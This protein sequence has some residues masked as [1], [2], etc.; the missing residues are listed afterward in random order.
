MA[1]NKIKVD[2]EEETRD[3]FGGVP[4]APDTGLIDEDRPAWLGY[5]PGIKEEDVT[6]AHECDVLVLGAGIAGISAARAAAE[7]G[8]N[9][10]VVEQS[11]SI[12]I[13]GK[14]FGCV[15]SH[16]HKELG[17]ET[18]KMDLLNL[19]MRRMGWRPNARLWKMWLDESGEAFD[20]FEAPAVKSGLEFGQHLQYWPN[21]P[22]Y[23]R[24]REL[25]PQYCAGIEFD[26][27]YGACKLHY[28]ESVAHGAKYF[29]RTTA[30]ELIKSEKGIMGAYATAEDGSLLKFTARK[31]VILATGDYGHNKEMAKALC[32]EFYNTLGLVA[33][34]W[35]T[36]MGHKMAI[37]A[38]GMMEEGPHA[39][40]SHSFPGSFVMGTTATLDLNAN[41]DRFMNE[42]V[43]GQIFTNQIIRQPFKYAWQIYD[44]NWADML[45][46]QN[47]AHGAIDINL[48]SPEKLEKSFE[49]AR[50]GKGWNMVAAD[51]L[52]ELIE[53]TGMPKERALE[54]I[55]RYNELCEKGVDEDFGKRGDRMYALVKPPFYACKSFI[56]RGMI[57]GGVVVD[58]ECRVLEKDTWKPLG[59]LYAIGNTGGGRYYC[60]YPVSPVCATS[61]GT[62][63]TFGRHVGMAAAKLADR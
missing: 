19:I 49:A 22:K 26:D 40:I 61:H 28:N 32:P 13:R 45:D 60:D 25:F 11:K 53:K 41:G 55:R 4:D 20:W 47:I 56:A 44:S 43:P 23:D 9:V 16:I 59:G 46:N 38:G 24:S 21:P 18:D 1:E 17:C 62:A 37:W 14:V 27:W 15:D 5:A 6:A 8:A 50:E 39:H 48:N 7:A 57:T 36:G 51:T 34:K 33:S 2:F 35:S 31:A 52:E 3:P 42:D 54:S 30:A 29:F 12:S 10:I 63:V 58:E